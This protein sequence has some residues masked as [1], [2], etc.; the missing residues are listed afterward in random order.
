MSSDTSKKGQ[1]RAAP[2]DEAS[3][4]S[5]RQE[6]KAKQPIDADCLLLSSHAIQVA[7]NARDPLV[8]S[9]FEIMY[10]SKGPSYETDDVQKAKH[11][12]QT[13]VDLVRAS[14]ATPETAEA[15]AALER[16]YQRAVKRLDELAEQAIKRDTEILFKAVHKVTSKPETTDKKSKLTTG[17]AKMLAVASETVGTHVAVSKLQTELQTTKELLEPLLAEES[18]ERRALKRLY[19]DALKYLDE[20]AS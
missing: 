1:K 20:L 19:E 5:H 17:L 2:A 4:A 3:V 15:R 16:L 13:N 6:P 11:D 7:P 8:K 10:V 12:L 14:C 9:C 18:D